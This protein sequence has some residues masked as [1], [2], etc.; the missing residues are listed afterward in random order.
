MAR[1]VGATRQTVIAWRAR[2][3]TGGIDPLADL[4]RLGRPPVVDEAAVVGATLN[5]PPEDLGIHALVGQNGGL[6]MPAPRRFSSGEGVQRGPQPAGCLVG[7]RPQVGGIAQL[8]QYLRVERLHQ[9]GVRPVGADHD[10]ARQ[11]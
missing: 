6:V 3:V 2:Y 8:H 7:N 11:E 9:G 5:P 10:V 1:R 4:P